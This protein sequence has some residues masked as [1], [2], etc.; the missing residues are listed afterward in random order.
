MS[1]QDPVLA[2][3][4]D[5][6]RLMA[7]SAATTIEVEAD[8]FAVTVTRRPGAT[9]PAAPAVAERL[10][11]DAAA[12]APKTQKVHAASVGIFNGPRAWNTGDSV[13]R[14]E[15]LGGIQTLGHTSEVKAPAD[16]E[17]REVLVTTGAPVEYGQALFVITVR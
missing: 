3:V 10:S 12:A 15:V 6:T 9:V 16:G 7:D 8:T 2:L 17:I 5:L 1:D 11:Q 14:G 13:T 4:D